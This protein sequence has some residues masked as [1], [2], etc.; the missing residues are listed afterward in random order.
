MSV[1]VGGGSGSGLKFNL[2]RY[3]KVWIDVIYILNYVKLLLIVNLYRES[4]KLEWGGG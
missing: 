3:L 4:M 1:G 2:F